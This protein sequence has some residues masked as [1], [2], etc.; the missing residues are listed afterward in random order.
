LFLFLFF[1]F[2]FFFF[3]YRNGL[4][5]IWWKI[6]NAANTQSIVLLCS[7]WLQSILGDN[8]MISSQ[9]VLNLIERENSEERRNQS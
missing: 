4:Q 6:A 8:R 2:F 9:T 5:W 7:Q 3:Q 1:F